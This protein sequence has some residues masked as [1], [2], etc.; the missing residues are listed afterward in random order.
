MRSLVVGAGGAGPVFVDEDDIARGEEPFSHLPSVADAVKEVARALSQAGIEAGAPH[1]DPTAD[2][3]REVWNE[4]LQNAAGRPLIVHFSGH[5][6][7][8]D[9]SLYLA[10]RESRRGGS[11][12]ATSVDVEALVKDAQAVS[13]PVL[14]ML[15]VCQAGQAV[16]GQ[17]VRELVLSTGGRRRTRNVWIIGACSAEEIT[18]Q[19]IFSRATTAVLR[20]LAEGLLDVSPGLEFVPVETFA[21]EVAREIACAGGVGQSVVRTPT[22]LALGEVPGFFLNP[23]FAPDA[24]G[25]FLAGVSM[26]LH[27]LAL[28][29]DPGIDLLHFATRAAGNKQVDV[30]QFSGR[31]SQ[32]ERI[33]QWLDNTDEGQ[34][35][36]LVVTG[37]PGT[38]KSALLGVTACLLHPEL[39]PLR[40][41]IRARLPGFD[42]RPDAK[43]VAV[44]ARQLTT[45]QILQSLCRQLS[46]SSPGASAD[47]RPDHARQD[48]DASKRHSTDDLATLVKDK[49]HVII[50]LDA[51][52]EATDPADVARELIYPLVGVGEREG[53]SGCRI[54]VGTRPWW[55]T[56]QGLHEAA[57]GDVGT[58][59]ALDPVTEEDRET[60]REDLAEYLGQLLDEHYPATTPCAVAERLAAHAQTGAFLIAA[61]FADHLL[62]QAWAGQPLS[63]VDIRTRLPCTITEVFDLHT[64]SV[65]AADRWLLPVLQILG[66]AR[67][68]GMP[69]ELLHQAALAHAALT[70]EA[71]QLP[72]QDDTRR[73]LV[74]ASFYL[75]TAPD[76]DHRLLYRYFH[77]ALNDHTA[78]AV[79][80]VTVHQALLASVPLASDGSR[81]WEYAHPYLKRHAAAHAQAAGVP[82]LDELLGEAEFLLHADPNGLMPYLHHAASDTAIHHA[83]IYRSTVLQRPGRN[84]VSTRRGLLAVDAAA[85]HNAALASA[86]A[87]SEVGDGMQPARPVWATNSIAHPARL[88]TFGGSGTTAGAVSAVALVNGGALAV[89]PHHSQVNVWDI[90]TGKQ[91]GTLD[92][93]ARALATVALPDGRALALACDNGM[94][95]VWDISAGTRI[96]SLDDTVRSMAALASSDGHALAVTTDGTRARVW[97]LLTGQHQRYLPSRG[98]FGDAVAAVALPDGRALGITVDLT[99]KA[100]VWDLNTGQCLSTLRGH[101]AK[102]RAV[103]AVALPDGRAF[104]VTASIGGAAIVWD[105]LTGTEHLRLNGLTHAARDVA[106]V[107]TPDGQAFAI[108][109]DRARKAVVWDLNTGRRVTTLTSRYRAADAIT[110]VALPDGRALAITTDRSGPATVWDLASSTHRRRPMP[111]HSAPVHSIVSTALPQGGSVALSSGGNVTFVWNLDT[112]EKLHTLDGHKTLRTELMFSSGRTLAQATDLG[113]RTLIWD[114]ESG[115]RLSP[116]HGVSDSTRGTSPQSVLTKA[117][118]QPPIEDPRLP[119]NGDYRL[120]PDV[121][122]AAHFRQVGTR[123][124]LLRCSHPRADWIIWNPIAQEV[125]RAAIGSPRSAQLEEW[126]AAW[127]TSRR[128]RRSLRSNWYWT[129]LPAELFERRH[130]N[131]TAMPLSWHENWRNRARSSSYPLSDPPWEDDYLVD[132][133]DFE[134]YDLGY[135]RGWTE[136]ANSQGRIFAIL[137]DSYPRVWELTGWQDIYQMRHYTGS[138]QAMTVTRLPDGRPVAVLADDEGSMQVWD[139]TQDR[140]MGSDIWLPQPAQVVTA[141][142]TGIIA[143]YGPEI[144]YLSW[145][146]DQDGP[147]RQ[148]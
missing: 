16:I 33:Q 22:D 75:R 84:D 88:H 91:L 124:V 23:S 34:T 97:D 100:M 12:R 120:M 98:R 123:P 42:P 68:L 80:P 93:R 83:H 116:H 87:R 55:E 10:V 63:D 74:K 57:A 19:A 118:P 40:R 92:Q 112:G 7:H 129:E 39:Q 11:L 38:G 143:G 49:G 26:A 130:R 122:R 21:A 54:M 81:Q 69:L 67:G 53:I 37:G 32:L 18:Q 2:Q 35:A 95:Q 127:Q 109:A 76:T 85:W 119:Q 9:G 147:L 36:L 89:T 4:A 60:L 3:F 15:D 29:V 128:S 47:D 114:L 117:S 70:D 56:L 6:E 64:K 65:A 94:A 71:S 72:M 144:A 113:G 28:S 62:Q 126:L 110:A 145:N 146:I 1:L 20:R 142:P 134:D 105:L 96:S 24:P 90:T 125:Q 51:L 148:H 82:F 99:R 25:R 141:T 115:D 101:I 104:A 44:H 31:S 138:V 140:K 48:A 5:G 106:A 102:V 52:D 111:G 58:V 133:W 43:V 73:A 121:Q 77:Q 59:L 132:D 135:Y 27:N 136:L 30:C 61:L 50:I 137:E 107:V 46:P 79:D 17:Q 66:Q 45:Q 139:L 86:F 78:S 13:A 103:A 41:Q 108:T 8:Q 14:F 131:T